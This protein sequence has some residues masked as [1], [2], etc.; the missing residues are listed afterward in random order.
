MEEEEFSAAILIACHNRRE[1]TL[2]FLRSLDEQ[3]GMKLLNAQIYLMDDGSTDGTADAVRAAFPQV[4][5]I[6]GNGKL[7]WAGGM[8]TLW[9]HATSQKKYD[10]YL[11]FNDD[12][13]L[14]P[15]AIERLICTYRK[16]NGF[17][18]IIIGSTISPST[19]QWSYGGRALYHPNEAAYYPVQP[20]RDNALPVQLGNANI[21][22]VDADTVDKIG[23]FSD[24]FTHYLAD[25]DY[26]L[27]AYKHGLDVLIAPGFYGYCEFDHDVNRLS[28][29]VPLKKRIEYLYSPKGLAYEEYL[30]YIKRHFPSDY[31]GAWFK[32]WMKTFFPVIWDKFK[33]GKD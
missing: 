26:T 15:D 16:V 17:G 7:Y 3:P 2:T 32:L 29:S 18:S 5:I 6:T 24:S 13:Q 33:K 22:M 14:M 31:T 1:K 4:Q 27:R 28:S 9:E 8:R 20:D 19:H 25:Y 10:L 21:F 11:L 23:I 30:L 12:V